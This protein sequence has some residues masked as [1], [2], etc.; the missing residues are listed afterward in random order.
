MLFINSATTPI[1]NITW[2][3]VD[4]TTLEFICELACRTP[5]ISGCSIFLVNNGSSKGFG[6]SNIVNGS[7]E[8]ISSCLTTVVVNDDV[9]PTADCTYIATPV[10]I[11]DGVSISFNSIRGIIPA[12]VAAIQGK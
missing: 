12:A 11:V 5:N 9:D 7:A 2:T 4:D 3:R 8:A 10:A 6:T 1:Y